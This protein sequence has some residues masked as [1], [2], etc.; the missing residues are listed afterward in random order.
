MLSKFHQLVGSHIGR[1]TR[2][3][4]H[5]NKV[6]IGTVL[7][8]LFA[9]PAETTNKTAGMYAFHAGCDGVAEEHFPRVYGFDQ[10][11]GRFD[12]FLTTIWK[13]S[14]SSIFRQQLNAHERNAKIYFVSSASCRWR[15]IDWWLN[16]WW[17]TW[18]RRN[19]S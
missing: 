4:E 3:M 10:H 8:Q 2:F 12:C 1:R 14:I 18:T 16:V 9:M 11:I 6:F 19:L 17:K 13:T 7:R 15:K 5:L